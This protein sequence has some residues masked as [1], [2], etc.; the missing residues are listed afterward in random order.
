MCLSCS[1]SIFYNMNSYTAKQIVWVELT[2]AH[3]RNKANKLHKIYVFTTLI[4]SLAKFSR[5]SDDY[6]ITD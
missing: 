6:L 4:Q 5:V 3:S 2:T 1:G